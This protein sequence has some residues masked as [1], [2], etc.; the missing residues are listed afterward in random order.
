MGSTGAACQSRKSLALH[1]ARGI[2][3]V[4]LHSLLPSLVLLLLRP[5]LALDDFALKEESSVTF[6]AAP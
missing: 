3:F 5:D 4:A 6:D 2:G 1:A